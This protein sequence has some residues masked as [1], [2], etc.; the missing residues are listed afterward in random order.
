MSAAHGTRVDAGTP[1]GSGGAAGQGGP[2]AGGGAPEGSPGEMTVGTLVGAA[3]HGDQRAWE[4]LLGRFDG[5]IAAVG[6][7]YGLG[8]A[9]VKDLQQTTWMR[10]IENLHRLEH[11]ERV[12]GWLATTA[13][14]ESLHLLSRSA[15]CTTGA[16]QMLANLADLRSPDLDAGPIAEERARVLTAAWARL[17]PRC[18][19]LLSLLVAEDAVGYK[20]LSQLLSMPVGSIGPTRGRCVEHL[21]RLVV[22]EG[23]TGL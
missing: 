18:Q 2:P 6:R 23:M 22:E 15:R 14:R 1:G 12:G 11:P 9:D 13:R 10:L 3:A 5:M 21:R 19:Q 20:E 4:E 7:R 17:K 16:D 8:P